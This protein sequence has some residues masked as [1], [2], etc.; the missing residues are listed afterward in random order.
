MATFPMDFRLYNNHSKVVEP[1][2][3]E[4]YEE[5]TAHLIESIEGHLSLFIGVTKVSSWLHK[6][7]Q[8]CREE[9]ENIRQN[10]SFHRSTHACNVQVHV[11]AVR[12]C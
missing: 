4:C 8:L 12:G 3:E 2:Y 9:K 5:M 6:T 10:T 7:H 1:V 11:P